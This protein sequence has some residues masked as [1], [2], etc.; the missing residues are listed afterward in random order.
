MEFPEGELSFFLEET[1]KD[2]LCQKL[3]TWSDLFNWKTE[4]IHGC[5]ACDKML[6]SR[7]GFFQQTI[8]EQ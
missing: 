7:Y 1:A 4:I 3:K 2:Y 5:E 8:T 6:S